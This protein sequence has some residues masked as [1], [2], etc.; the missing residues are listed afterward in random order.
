MTAIAWDVD[1]KP[2]TPGSLLASTT[3]QA[4]AAFLSVLQFSDPFVMPIVKHLE[5]L[6]VEK[7]PIFMFYRDN[8]IL[9]CVTCVRMLSASGV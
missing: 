3:E 5:G 1:E 2:Y 4:H 9:L 8:F 7:F 6:I